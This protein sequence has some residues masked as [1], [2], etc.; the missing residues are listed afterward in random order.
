[1]K[2]LR[3]SKVFPRHE[4]L[5]VLELI[6]ELGGSKALKEAEKVEVP[7]VPEDLFQ[8]FILGSI[9]LNTCAGQLFDLPSTLIFNDLIADFIRVQISNPP[10]VGLVVG[11]GLCGGGISDGRIRGP[12]GSLLHTIKH[13]YISRGVSREWVQATYLNSEH[14]FVACF[15]G[16][17]P[18]RWPQEV[19]QAA[20]CFQFQLD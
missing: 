16:R 5:K 7:L 19:V 11:S 13:I 9:T 12:D 17:W 6:E 18:R 14:V 8:D 15:R 3:D 20:G 4:A 1:M 2:L 10:G